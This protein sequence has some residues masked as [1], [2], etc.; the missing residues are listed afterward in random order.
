MFNLDLNISNPWDT[1]FYLTKWFF[2]KCWGATK[3]VVVETALSYH[4]ATLFTLELRYSI[5]CDHAGL[6][7]SIALLGLH[8][9]FNWY[10]TRHW[11]HYADRWMTDEE[12]ANDYPTDEELVK[13][14]EFEYDT[15]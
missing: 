11:N 6:A 7:F 10:D 9:Q 14:V 8:F 1:K 2:L 15:H 5:R 3:N 12:C 13:L 4:R